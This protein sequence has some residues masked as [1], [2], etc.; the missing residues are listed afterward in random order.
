MNKSLLSVIV[1]GAMLCGASVYAQDEAERVT[2]KTSD[3]FYFVV[4]DDEPT[5][6]SLLPVSDGYQGDVVTV[7]SAATDPSTGITYTVTTIG[8]QAFYYSRCPKVVY[9]ATIA[10]IDGSALF[11]SSVA[12]VEIAEGNE[13]YLSVD[14]IVYTKDMTTLWSFPPEHKYDGYVLP[15]TVTAIGDYAFCGLFYLSSFEIPARVKSIGE[16]AFMGT[17]LKN[18]V[19][20]S[21]V[22]SVGSAAFQNC[23]QLVS[24]EFP[25]GMTLMPDH[26]LTYCSKLESVNLP[27]SLTKIGGYAFNGAFIY[28]KTYGFK[29]VDE[30]TV[31][32]EVTEIEYGAFQGNRGLV[33]VTLGKKVS[34]IGL[35]AFAQCSALKSLTSLNTV[36]PVCEELDQAAS[37]VEDAFAEV[38]EDCVLYVPAES[39]DAYKAAWGV[40]FTDIRPIDSA[41]IE[42]AGLES[43]SFEVNVAG[44]VLTVVAS[45]A[46]EVY[47]CAGVKVASSHDGRV[48]ASLPAGVYIVRGAGRVAKVAL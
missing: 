35:F 22:E 15:E 45:G 3:G 16:A 25:E 11:N 48:A 19:I 27:S 5:S 44:G 31:P 10:K 4:N 42:D 13:T 30:I 33:S 37:G 47:N 8:E 38:P 24:I 21:T 23:K 1:S 2:F 46:V 34:N 28:G 39:V 14:G 40:K 6:V 26:V 36:P 41:G 9:P 12:D 17:R 29:C 7:P 18:I 32:D 20:P 43:G